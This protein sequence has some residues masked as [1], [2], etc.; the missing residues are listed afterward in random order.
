MNRIVID[1]E[2]CKGCGFCIAYCPKEI[3]HL[4]SKCNSLGFKYAET[5]AGEGACTACKICAL[6]CPDAAITVFRESR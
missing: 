3:I 6:M 4:G 2:L 1:Q 5:E